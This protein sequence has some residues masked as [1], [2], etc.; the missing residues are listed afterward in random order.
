[1]LCSAIYWIEKAP[2]LPGVSWCRLFRRLE[3]RGE[4]RGGRFISGVAGE[5]Y[6]TP[7]A[8]ELL[9]RCAMR[10]ADD[11][12]VVLAAADPI[13]LCGL[14]TAEPRIPHV[15]TNTVAIRNGRLIG[16][17]QAGELQ[18]FGEISPNELESLSRRLRLQYH[19]AEDD[20]TSARPTAVATIR[21]AVRAPFH[22]SADW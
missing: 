7:E 5:Q 19:L 20:E 2:H 18:W 11:K 22:Q 17:C 4:I 13:N 6:A 3:A 1:M 8:V 12:T 16:A 10:S 9:R 15:H 21:G 14:I